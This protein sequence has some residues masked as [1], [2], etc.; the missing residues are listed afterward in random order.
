MHLS[1]SNIAW[2]EKND[3]E[4]LGYLQ[5][6]SF[7][8]IE[9]APTRIFGHNPYSKLKEAQQFSMM[10][11]ETYKLE[12][13][14]IQSILYGKNEN[15]FGKEDERINLIEYLKRS[16]DFASLINCKN[17]VFGCP[18]N[19][20]LKNE[21]DM[22]IAFSFFKE[23]GIYASN[24]NTVLS[25]EP[26]PIIYNTNFINYT[27]EAFDFVKKIDNDGFKVNFDLGTMIYNKEELMV[28][29]NNIDY[30]N[31]IHISEPYLKIIKNRE[32]HKE[33]ASILKEKKYNKFVSIEMGKCDNIN[34]VKKIISYINEVFE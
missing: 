2:D 19:R 1:I 8:G 4:M 15:I 6:C 22:E 11:G 16:I 24:K 26:N 23:L 14:S 5:E 10:I 20:V 25:I 33:L 7:S 21:E 27:Q 3:E 30:V 17:I 31:H 13:A 18:K 34:D 29:Y 28:I 9:I 12:I 32:L